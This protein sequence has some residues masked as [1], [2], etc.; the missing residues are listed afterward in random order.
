M[1]GGVAELAD[2]GLLKSPGLHREGSSPFLATKYWSV[3]ER[4]NQ[5]DEGFSVY[6]FAIRIVGGIDSLCFAPKGHFP[7]AGPGVCGVKE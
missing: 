1:F 3:L 4:Y 2:A 7:I 6:Y 5:N